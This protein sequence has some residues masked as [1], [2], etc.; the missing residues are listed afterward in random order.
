VSQQGVNQKLQRCHMFE[1][2][3]VGLG[4]SLQHQRAG[5]ENIVFHRLG[6]MA[7]PRIEV[8]S[9]AFSHGS[10]IPVQYTA[11][12]LGHSP[13]LR[14]HGVP[15]TTASIVLIVEDADSPTPHPLVHA[16]VVN[17]GV[18]DAQLSEGAINSPDH[19]GF[20]LQ[21][22]R[23]SFLQQSWLPPDPPPGHGPHRY[24]FQVFALHTGEPFS[25]VPGRQEI[26][27]AVEARVVAGGFLIGTYG[28][29]E[30][31]KVKSDQEA[32]IEAEA[33]SEPMAVGAIA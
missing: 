28:R 31:A 33:Q 20:A 21:V 4:A 5:I 6:R 1:K 9:E 25:N 11:D 13:P 16:I 19:R 27:E 32:A 8:Q 26:Y 7:I 22:G 30:R 3:P 2:L 17:M 23:N 24:V 14:W 18:D 12:G 29:E 10:S 15:P